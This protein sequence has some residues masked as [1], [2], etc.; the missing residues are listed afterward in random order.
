MKR[1]L[2]AIDPPH[3]LTHQPLPRFWAL[4]V[5]L[6][7]ALPTPAAETEQAAPTTAV[8]SSAESTP[9]TGSSLSVDLLESRIKE[10]ESSTSLTEEAKTKLIEQYR[11]ALSA[12]EQAKAFEAKTAAFRAAIDSAPI[13]ATSI[14][15]E[16]EAS[17]KNK[18]EPA[19]VI[20]EGADLKQIERL[21]ARRTGRIRRGRDADR[22]I[23][24]AA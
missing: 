13:E 20:P 12:L 5:L 6:L 2:P 9:T 15:A 24:Q 7:P 23:G 11:G 17:Q 16:I 14:R 1:H 4:L 18:P 10:T 21:L 19:A 22:G 8:V 3:R